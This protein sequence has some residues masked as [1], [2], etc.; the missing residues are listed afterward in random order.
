[1]RPVWETENSIVPAGTS[2]S[3]SNGASRTSRRCIGE[4]PAYS[5][6]AS[7][8][9]RAAVE[10]PFGASTGGGWDQSGL[11]VFLTA[12]FAVGFAAWWA[13]FFE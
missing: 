11:L 8:I 13:A 2:S 3:S 5:R 4:G 10:A 1:M 9:A 7:S 6:I 12:I